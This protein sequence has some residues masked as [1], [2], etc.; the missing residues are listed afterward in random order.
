MVSGIVTF[1]RVPVVAGLGLD[2][3]RTVRSP[4]RGVTV[5]LT[6]NGAAIASTTTD[7]AGAYSFDVAAN[8]TVAL[9]VRAEM[10]RSGAPSWDFRVV[11]NVNGNALYVLDGMPF[12]SGTANSTRDL[13]AASGWTGTGYT[14]AR[15][16][17]PFA[18]LDVIYA[19]AELV[20]TATPT[21]A[22]PALTLHWS[23]SNVPVSGPGAGEIGSSFFRPGV[24]IFLVG[25][26]DQDTDEYDRH[27]IAHEWGHYLEY[28]FSRSDSIGGRH[29][30]TDQLDMRLA[31]AEAWGNAF[32]AMATGER[33]YIDAFGPKQGRS[34]SFDLEQSPSRRNP[35]PGWFNE[36]SVQSLL[37][38]LFDNGRDVPPN[39]LALDDLALGFA[40]VFA[41]L[42]ESQRSTEALTTVFPL[43]SAL[44]QSRPADVP[45]IDALTVSQ[46]ITAVADDYGSG[47]TNFGVP[48]SQ[49]DAQSVRADFGSVYHTLTVGGAAVNV[50]SLDDFASTTTGAA[51]KL[52][53][54]RFVRFSVDTPGMHV[55]TARAVAPLNAAADPDMELYRAGARVASSS[56]P[57]QCT[58]DSPQDCVEAFAPDL[59]AG[60]YVLEVFE[61]TN[62][63]DIDDQ[64]PP[65]GRTCFDVTVT[66]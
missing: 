7:A 42:T 32:S 64:Y 45:L 10:L 53:A 49:R 14:A 44:K 31:F 65:I 3:T 57:P 17:A 2:Y 46:R 43:V 25:A 9:R 33:V 52:A 61:W 59:V 20:L 11:D 54:R 21:A 37:F 23:P 4:A 48:T 18:I 58:V 63:N 56:E 19:S 13:N 28:Y 15:S 41:A 30:L 62:T 22:F 26:V 6:S 16:A 34:F 12:D 24:G 29:T 1:D 38:D 47:E 35:N 66:R 27:V 50:C 40:P 51:N 39:S 55:I 60:N 8:T 5:E 36:E